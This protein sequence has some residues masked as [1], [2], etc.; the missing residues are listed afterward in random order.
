MRNCPLDP[1][2]PISPNSFISLI[3]RIIIIKERGLLQVVI[4][5]YKELLINPN[6]YEVTYQFLLGYLSSY[7]RHRGMEGRVG[8]QS[9]NSRLICSLSSWLWVN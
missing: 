1:S 8:E 9:S 7:F 3:V 4:I 2:K 6:F 5:Y